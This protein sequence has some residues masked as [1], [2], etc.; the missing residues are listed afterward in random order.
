MLSFFL[1][2]IGASELT[3]RL[4]RRLCTDSTHTHAV[5]AL[6][7]WYAYSGRKG[8]AHSH[9]QRRGYPATRS[10]KQEQAA[11]RQAV[12]RYPWRQERKILVKLVDDK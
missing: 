12:Q 6:G 9:S 8:P 4:S 3:V 11:N 5:S 10:G 1:N 7:P 2:P